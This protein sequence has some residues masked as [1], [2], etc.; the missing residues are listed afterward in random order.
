MRN[1]IFLGVILLAPLTWAADDI[2]PLDV[3]LGLW[4]STVN[5]QISGRPPLPD[6]VLSR[7]S[8]DQRARMEDALKAQQAKGGIVRT[9][10]SCL[11][12]EKLDQAMTF[13]NEGANCKRTVITSNSSKQEIRFECTDAQS[14]MKT[15][16]TMHVE[17]LNSENVKGTGQVK[18]DNGANNMNVQVNFT[19]KWLGSDCGAL[20]KK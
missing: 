1:L 16:G 11:T 15:D 17:A 18:A 6:E 13:G 9:T 7:L 20:G 4:E 8:P 3:K 10:K 2:K 19:A 14:N 5:S 12:K